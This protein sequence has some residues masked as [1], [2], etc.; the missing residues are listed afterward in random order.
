MVWTGGRELI[1]PT[2]AED[3][4]INA[5]APSDPDAPPLNDTE[6]AYSRPARGRPTSAIKRS[7]FPFGWIPTSWPICAQA[8][9]AGKWKSRRNPGRIEHHVPGKPECLRQCELQLSATGTAP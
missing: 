4:A 9:K 8:A 1:L 7:C 6:L 5:A 2:S 3:A